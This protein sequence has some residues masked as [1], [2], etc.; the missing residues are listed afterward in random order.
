V[1]EREHRAGAAEAGLHLVDAEERAVRATQ[2]LRALEVAG[3]R[4][5]APLSLDRL[6]DEDRDVLRAQL[7]L[8]R[9]EV[10]EGNVVEARQ[11]RPEPRGELLVAV[12]GE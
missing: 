5:V 2:V 8:E 4:K 6:D 11:Q 7:L 12:R 3:G 1:L 10:A 9:V